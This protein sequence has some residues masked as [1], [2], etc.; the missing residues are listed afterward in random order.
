MKLA[1]HLAARVLS[2]S[3]ETEENSDALRALLSS[4]KGGAKITV[5]SSPGEQPSQPV[6]L[7]S[8][9]RKDSD[10]NRVLRFIAN[11]LSRE[12]RKAIVDEAEKYVDEHPD[13]FLR[14]GREPWLRDRKLALTTT[15][16]CFHLTFSMAAYP[17]RKERAVSLVREI[18]KTEQ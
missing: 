2:N 7:A 14:F 13:F 15:G 4:G 17:K 6:L 8:S 11:N 5:S 1:H 18:F 10:I 16:D 3:S 12:D 9:L